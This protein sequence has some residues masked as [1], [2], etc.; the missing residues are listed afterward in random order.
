MT[1]TTTIT[2][3]TQ[4]DD[5]S[6]RPWTPHQVEQHTIMSHSQYL[7]LVNW[8]AKG[9]AKKIDWGITFLLVRDKQIE[10]QKEVTPETVS[11]LN[12]ILSGVNDV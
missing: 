1:R 12:D 7:N 5:G 4:W 8:E 2:S 10:L 9:R 6:T 11:R 3:G